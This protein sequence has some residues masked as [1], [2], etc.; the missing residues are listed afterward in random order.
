MEGF[1]AE[2]L[3]VAFEYCASSF[4]SYCADITFKLTHLCASHCF[5]FENLASVILLV[6]PLC[7]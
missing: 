2:D 5:F 3:A 1:L 7:V 4:T 6:F